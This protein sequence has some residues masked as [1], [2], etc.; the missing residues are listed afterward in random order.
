[1]PGPDLPMDG[2]AAGDS[3]WLQQRQSEPICSP[4]PACSPACRPPVHTRLCVIAVLGV[5]SGARCRTSIPPL[6][7]ETLRIIS[8]CGE[9][10]PALFSTLMDIQDVTLR[11]PG[12]ESLVSPCCMGDARRMVPLMSRCTVTLDPQHG[13]KRCLGGGP[14]RAREMA[15]RS[16]GH[17][18]LIT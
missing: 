9:Q 11:A 16:S 10:T 15:Q 18:S 7:Q 6:L 2:W 14:L 8:Q 1:M 12:N 5:I 17:A 13:V 4:G 3:S